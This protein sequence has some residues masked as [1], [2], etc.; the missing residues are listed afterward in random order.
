VR[1]QPDVPVAPLERLDRRLAVDHRR[2]DLAVLSGGLL[3]YDH[4]VAV[5]DGRL[6]HR[7]AGDLE[8]EEGALADELAG[9]WEHVLDRLLGQHRATGGDPAHQRHV[10]R[11]R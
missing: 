9:E 10:R 11:R 6:D 8:H 2:D 3:T 5:A 4:P 1:Q 7:V